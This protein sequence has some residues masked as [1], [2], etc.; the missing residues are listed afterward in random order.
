MRMKYVVL[1]IITALLAFPI[2]CHSAPVGS[3]A[4]ASRE[5]LPAP[6]TRMPKTVKLN[7][8]TVVLPSPP[9]FALIDNAAGKALGQLGVGEGSECVACFLKPTEYANAQRG[10][11]AMTATGMVGIE[12]DLRD[13]EVSASRFAE[14]RDHIAANWGVPAASEVQKALPVLADKAKGTLDASGVSAD[15]SK[16]QINN[17]GVAAKAADYVTGIMISK[18]VSQ[19]FRGEIRTGDYVHAVTFIRLRQRLFVLHLNVPITTP[20]DI[21]ATKTAMAIWV[22][23]TLKRNSRP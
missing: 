6:L 1:S 7:A 23:D 3:G 8:V 18:N 20:S 19:T 14:V 13:G 22:A 15:L 21:E 17:V 5:A 2:I 4:P 9:G 16:T 12:T 10:S 11:T